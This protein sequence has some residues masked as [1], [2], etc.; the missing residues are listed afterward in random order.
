M[1]LEDLK[2]YKLVW[3]DEF[4]G[5]SLDNTKWDLSETDVE[6]QDEEGNTALV[7]KD[8]EKLIKVDDG[9]LIL[10]SYYD[11]ENK[12]YVSHKSVNT[13]EKMSFK[14]GYL[15]VRAKMPFIPGTTTTLW[16]YAKDAIGSEKDAVYYSRMHVF[17]HKGFFAWLSSEIE[18]V[19]EN[20]DENH[21][22]YEEKMS[23]VDSSKRAQ[24]L[25]LNTPDSYHEQYVTEVMEEYKTYGFLWTPDEVVF[26]ADGHVLTRMKLTQDFLRPSGVEGFRKP[27]Y[28]EFATNFFIT[29]HVK[30]NRITP[31]RAARKIPF[32]IDYIRLYQK[33]G[34]GELNLGK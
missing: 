29:E 30:G 33:Q 24:S 13:K 32:E 22:F 17:G 4:D 6:K 5:N 26:T 12:V 27:H 28:L 31:E 25:G 16:A 2:D 11:E 3:S 21:P 10:S 1:K 20:Y 7:F 18:K 15:E 19:Y 14:Y 23:N 34:E 9:K 8:G